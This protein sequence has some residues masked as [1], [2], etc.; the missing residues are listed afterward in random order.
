MRTNPQEIALLLTGGFGPMCLLVRALTSRK[1]V[2]AA[3]AKLTYLLA[4]L[5]GLAWG[6][7]GF[8]VLEPSRVAPR[9]LSLLLAS[10]YICGGMIIGFLLSVVIARP[11]HRR[12]ATHAST[13]APKQI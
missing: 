6:V 8:V 10:K 1:C 2:W 9:T 7:I 13:A 4:S 12:L 11:C 3:W 5:A